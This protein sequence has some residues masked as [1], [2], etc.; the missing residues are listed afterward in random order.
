MDKNMIMQRQDLVQVKMRGPE[1]WGG[2]IQRLI[3]ALSSFIGLC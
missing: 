3:L 1:T 2:D